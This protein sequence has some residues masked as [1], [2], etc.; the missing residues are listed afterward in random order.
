[1]VEM[2]FAMI[3][4]SLLVIISLACFLVPLFII[5]CIFCG[6]RSGRK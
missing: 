2:A 6:D 5:S 3:G 1:M 4:I